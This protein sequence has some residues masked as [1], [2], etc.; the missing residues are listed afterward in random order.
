MLISTAVMV[1]VAKIAYDTYGPQ[2]EAWLK[3]VLDSDQPAQT[4][5]SSSSIQVSDAARE[6]ARHAEGYESMSPE[7]REMTAQLVER[8]MQMGGSAGQPSS[9]E[10][11]KQ[12]QIRPRRYDRS[13]FDGYHISEL[14]QKTALELGQKYNWS[15]SEIL[16]FALKLEKI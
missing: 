13:I 16:N 8:I 9:S 10:V 15:R 4:S 2:V 1:A 6:H 14:V 7:Q 5:A 3:D 12:P 11:T